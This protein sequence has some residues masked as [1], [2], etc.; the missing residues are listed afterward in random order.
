MAAI[1][2]IVADGR[3]QRHGIMLVDDSFWRASVA[4]VIAQADVCIERGD[5][6][7]A[8]FAQPLNIPFPRNSS[9]LLRPRNRR[10]DR[11]QRGRSVWDRGQNGRIDRRPLGRG[12]QKEQRVPIVHKTLSIQAAI[13]GNVG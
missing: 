4:R 13:W 1:V 8:G 12:C 5:K 7:G 9:Q 6:N 10:I 3:R 11:R 2:T